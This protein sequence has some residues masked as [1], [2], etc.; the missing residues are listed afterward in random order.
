MV[1]VLI[2]WPGPKQKGWEKLDATQ[3]LALQLDERKGIDWPINSETGNAERTQ[4]RTTEKEI[5]MCAR[6]H[7]RR[8]PISKDYVHGER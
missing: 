4:K 5:E 6:C 3:G 8:S 1:R 7:A 2:T